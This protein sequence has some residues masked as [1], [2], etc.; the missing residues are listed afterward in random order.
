MLNRLLRYRSI[1]RGKSNSTQ[2]K[3]D[4]ANGNNGNTMGNSGNN[5]NNNMDDNAMEEARATQDQHQQN[6]MA[7]V[8][9]KRYGRYQSN[10]IPEYDSGASTSATSSVSS[11][12][13][14]NNHANSSS[15]SKKRV[16][17]LLSCGDQRV[18]YSERDV[19]LVLTQYLA[20]QVQANDQAI[21]DR[22]MQI[23]QLSATAAMTVTTASSTSS[24]ATAAMLPGQDPNMK[25][26]V[27]S[28][29][30]CG[31]SLPPITL[32]D[33]IER[34]IHYLASVARVDNESGRDEFVQSDLGVRYI[35]ASIIYLK[36]LTAAENFLL[37]S[38]NIHRLLITAI[39]IASKML[40]DFQPRNSY[41]AKLGGVTLQELNNFECIFCTLLK[42]D[43]VIRPEEYH[44]LF[45][46]VLSELERRNHF[47]LQDNIPQLPSSSTSA[48]RT[49]R[50]PSNEKNK[51]NSNEDNA[52]GSSGRDTQQ[53]AAAA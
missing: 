2:G 28:D 51:T 43:L 48:T 8:N 45:N 26:V 21:S 3:D 16:V 6:E 15:T 30:F 47:V 7:R 20:P 32:Q 27:Y 22:A 24:T 11:S 14:G 5:G 52:K 23:R 9:N 17:R 12:P 4:A 35:V 10:D 18:H 25:I 31:L 39:T 1:S 29:P 42:F 49:A 34:L 40:D 53:A 33:Y 50:T 36:R 44:E 41:F 38:M 13:T 19:A 37:C 46:S